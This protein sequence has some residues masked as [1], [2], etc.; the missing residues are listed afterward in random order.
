M[1]NLQGVNAEPEVFHQ[2]PYAR[3]DIDDKDR[4]VGCV[5]SILFCLV[6]QV[7]LAYHVA[8]CKERAHACG[9]PNV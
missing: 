2:M 9:I 5:S 6:L 8:G 3:D 7:L 4:Q 1:T